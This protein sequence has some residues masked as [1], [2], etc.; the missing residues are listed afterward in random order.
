ACGSYPV[1]CHRSQTDLTTLRTA[2]AGAYVDLGAVG[3]SCVTRG[4]KTLNDALPTAP[5]GNGSFV[6]LGGLLGLGAI[7]NHVYLFSLKFR[8]LLGVRCTARKYRSSEMP[9]GA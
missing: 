4:S 9:P 7:C 6:L 8:T 5:D 3:F 1:V 2:T